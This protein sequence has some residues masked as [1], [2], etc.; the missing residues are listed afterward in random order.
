METVAD[1]GR[2][3]GKRN[4]VLLSGLEVRGSQLWHRVGNRVILH[5]GGVN[6]SNCPP[7]VA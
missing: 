4:R 2:G 3:V 5:H 1:R 6:A 7:A